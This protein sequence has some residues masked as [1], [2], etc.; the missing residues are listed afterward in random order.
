M[1]SFLDPYSDRRDRILGKAASDQRIIIGSAFQI[2]STAIPCFVRLCMCAQ[3]L[4]SRSAG[5][6]EPCPSGSTKSSDAQTLR[7][8]IAGIAVL[9]DSRSLGSKVCIRSVQRRNISCFVADRRLSST[10]TGV[11]KQ[12]RRLVAVPANRSR[13]RLLGRIRT[14]FDGRLDPSLDLR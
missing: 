3:L 5:P 10:A 13:I 6:D 1:R 11:L 7:T 9:G 12:A 14:I 2:R 8:D 4:C